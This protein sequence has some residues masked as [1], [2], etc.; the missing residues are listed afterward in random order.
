MAEALI[1][2]QDQNEFT[3]QQLAAL[4]ALGVE[5]A[6]PGDLM[7]FL[8]TAQRTGLDPFS[9]QI[10]MV[11]RR[12][13]VGD[14]WVTKQTI[15]VG[16]DGFRLVARRAASASGE[17]FSM[18]DTLWADDEGHWHDLWIWPQP[19]TAAKVVV[20]RGEG[21]F[22]G[23]ATY[24]EYVGTKRDKST[25]KQV[26][27]SMWAAKPA[28]MLAKCAE[29]LALRKAFPNDLANVYTPDEMDNVPSAPPQTVQQAGEIARVGKVAELTT[30]LRDKG[31]AGWADALPRIGRIL[32][33]EVTNVDDLTIED[34]N[35]TITAL[36]TK[37]NTNEAE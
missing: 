19:P 21:T 25:G 16:I 20:H 15:Q 28:L 32:G 5:E 34:M 36:N 8:N 33:R 1:L 26:P 2:R 31:F 7:L 30:L 3:Q 4:R 12:Q 14:S 11:G 24:Q 27:N 22:S 6:S 37:E 10:Y 13:K 18:D 35:R 17:K 9:K 29:A 23:V